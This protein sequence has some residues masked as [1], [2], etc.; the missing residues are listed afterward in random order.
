MFTPQIDG[1]LLIVERISQ[2]A[3]NGAL[4]YIESTIPKG[5]FEILHHRFHVVHAPHRWY[6]LEEKEHGIN[7]LRC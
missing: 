7:Q 6:A 4:V 1:L 5:V 3:K 2:E